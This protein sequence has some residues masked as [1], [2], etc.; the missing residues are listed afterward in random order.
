MTRGCISRRPALAKTA[1]D[2]AGST[3]SAAVRSPRNR[4]RN[5]AANRGGHAVGTNRRAD[6]GGDAH[7][8]PVGLG[9]CGL[10]A[11]VHRFV[12]RIFLL[13]DDRP[14]LMGRRRVFSDR[15]VLHQPNAFAPGATDRAIIRCH[16]RGTLV[17]LGSGRDWAFGLRLRTA[18]RSKAVAWSRRF[19]CGRRLEHDAR[20]GSRGV[21]LA[22]IGL[23]RLDP[24]SRC[25]GNLAGRRPLVHGRVGMC[26]SWPRKRPSPARLSAARAG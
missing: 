7:A 10:D 11:R 18:S 1:H 25:R 6:T 4:P 13:V 17:A 20:A 26:L 23:G 3:T 16:L 8:R 19:A 2:R 22:P 12:F 9:I 21:R 5:G 15:A 14:L 24:P